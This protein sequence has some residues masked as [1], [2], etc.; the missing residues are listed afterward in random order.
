MWLSNLRA[1]M[2]RALLFDSIGQFLIV[3]L[4]YLLSS[5]LGFGPVSVYLFRQVP[6]FLF[7]LSLY[8]LLGWLFGIY[9]VLGWRRLS[10]YV[11]LQRLFVTAFSTLLLVAFARSFFNHSDTLWLLSRPVLFLWISLLSLWAL[12]LRLALRRGLLLSDSPKILLLAEPQEL[13]IILSAW[14]RVHQ[15]QSLR[16]VSP[17]ELLKQLDHVEDSFL[18]AITPDTRNNPSLQNILVSLE[19]R[20]PRQVRALS[21]LSL[22]HSSKSVYR[23][24]CW[25]TCPLLMMTFPGQRPLSFQHSLSVWPISLFP[26]SCFL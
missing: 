18:L 26:R 17:T 1:L 14:H 4:I 11:L 10:P 6:W 9:T 8:P 25:T 5:T 21:L 16:P 12:A 23:R 15:R 13:Q 7:V 20:D 24:F 3:A 2:L 22:L 19:K